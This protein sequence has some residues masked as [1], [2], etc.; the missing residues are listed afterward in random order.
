ME[1]ELSMITKSIMASRSRSSGTSRAQMFETFDPSTGL[2][3]YSTANMEAF[4][5]AAGLA[6]GYKAA[7][8]EAAR[9]LY[10][11]A[12][13]PAGELK[14]TDPEYPR[15][16]AFS[17]TKAFK[18]GMYMARF[19]FLRDNARS[20]RPLTGMTQSDLA[21]IGAAKLIT[22]EALQAKL[23]ELGVVQSQP[24]TWAAAVDWLSRQ[25]PAG[26]QTVALETAAS[27]FNVPN[28]TTAIKGLTGQAKKDALYEMLVATLTGRQANV[29]SRPDSRSAVPSTGFAAMN[30][31]QIKEFAKQ[32][33]LN[34]PRISSLRRNELVDAVIA[35]MGGES[36]GMAVSDIQAQ[37]SELVAQS[38]SGNRAA[39]LQAFQNMN[40]D[41]LYALGATALQQLYRDLNLSTEYRQRFQNRAPS[42]TGIV[43]L[44]TGQAPGRSRSRQARTDIIQNRDACASADLAEVRRV[45]ESRGVRVLPGMSQADICRE[46]NASYLMDL[47]ALMLGRAQAGEL[48]AVAALTGNAQTA[49]LNTLANNLQMRGVTSLSELINR[50]L[51]SHY[52]GR[53]LSLY[54][55]AE[56]DVRAFLQS[57]SLPQSESALRNLANV[58]GD[59]DRNLVNAAAADQRAGLNAL[60][61]NFIQ[62]VRAGDVR[63]IEQNASRFN[64]G[65]ARSPSPMMA[66]S[67][68]AGDNLLS[69]S[70]VSASSG[71]TSPARS[72]AGDGFDIERD[73]AGDRRGLATPSFGFGASPR[74][75]SNSRGSS[76]RSAGTSSR[77][78]SSGLAGVVPN[79]TSASSP[80]ISDFGLGGA[81][82]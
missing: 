61:S 68:A 55:R 14:V 66:S 23:A 82:F 79:A 75:R 13:I 78:M 51:E 28:R 29:Q 16:S 7:E 21:S 40:P 6:D 64:F 76:P 46:L 49:R 8:R 53:A 18:D 80:G 47:S 70:P 3:F 26:W 57:G 25:N 60:Y 73:N 69:F 56:A 35:A 74:S 17:K 67:M 22:V 24:A 65:A 77:V 72:M 1:F 38:R 20:L 12:G 34:I 50:W 63:A 58:F 19:N 54:P 45:A 71:R 36:A 32:R 81:S 5:K 31:T 9:R 15:K 37:V 39:A 4:A 62:R 52:L 27:F 43:E 59:I 2:N 41:E 44:L 42:G 30:M 11:G 10:E 33:G 48:S